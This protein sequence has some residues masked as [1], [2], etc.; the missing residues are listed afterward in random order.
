MMQMIL[1][2]Q[3]KMQISNVMMQMILK[4][5][6]QILIYDANALEDANANFNI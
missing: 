6:M 3:M 5:Q 4:I 2:M 1:K